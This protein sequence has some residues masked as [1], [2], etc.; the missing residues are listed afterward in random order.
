M[1]HRFVADDDDFEEYSP[2]GLDGL[3]AATEKLLAVNRGLSEPDERDALPNDRI[4]TPDRLVKERVKLDHGR[5]LRTLMGRL[6]R[7]K[8]LTAMAPDAF[9]PYTVGYLD[10]NP[11]APALEEIN[12]MHIVEQQRRITKMGPGGVGDPNAITAAMQSVHA[13]QFGFIDTVAGPESEKA[14]VDVRLAWGA[15]IG[16]DGRIY[17]RVRNRSGKL[18]WV[19]P[20]QLVGKTLKLPD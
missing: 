3:L 6:S 12:P 7:T 11:L 1:H 14:G 8:S 13:S 2:I 20:T 16:S 9:S 4:Y 19:S 17:Q 5:T 15:K 18:E 10:G